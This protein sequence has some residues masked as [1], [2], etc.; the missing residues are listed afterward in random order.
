[1]VKFGNRI[2]ELLGSSHRRALADMTEDFR[3]SSQTLQQNARPR[4]FPSKS[5]PNHPSF[6]RQHIV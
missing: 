1:M 4:S 2:R 3:C 6:I 5:F